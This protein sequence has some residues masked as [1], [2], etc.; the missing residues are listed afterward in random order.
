MSIGEYAAAGLVM[1]EVGVYCCCRMPV[2]GWSTLHHYLHDVP[3]ERSFSAT[4]VLVVCSACQVLVF[5][6]RRLS[7]EPVYRLE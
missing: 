2:P 7:G 5:V 4:R 3:G 6:N 1:D